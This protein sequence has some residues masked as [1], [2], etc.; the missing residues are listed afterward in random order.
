MDDVCVVFTRLDRAFLGVDE[1]LYDLRDEC[2]TVDGS[3]GSV[4]QEARIFVVGLF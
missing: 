1:L 4:G 2:I 3:A